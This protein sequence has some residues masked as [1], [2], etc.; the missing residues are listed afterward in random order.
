MTRADIASPATAA[1]RA[2]SAI[3]Q[4]G[5]DPAR[6]EAEVKRD[7][8]ARLGREAV[9]ATL[10]APASVM[11]TFHQGLPRPIQRPDGS[12]G[13]EG[14]GAG[15]AHRTSQGWVGWSGGSRRLL[16]AAASAE[17]DSILAGQAFWGEPDFVRP[18]CTDAGA[19]RM[20][21]RHVA[22]R[23]VRQQSCGGIGLTGRLF[24]LVFAG[25]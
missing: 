25:R 18:G 20:V 7:V 1:G 19:R 9:A 2:S 22:R 14:P 4:P 5:F 23:T 17:L 8:E 24:D 12:F 15:A 16:P 13:Y 10:A 3:A 6:V 11:V 21:V